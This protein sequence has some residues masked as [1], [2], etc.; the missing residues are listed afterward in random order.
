MTRRAGTPRPTVE[1]VLT[2]H[3][4]KALIDA[5]HLAETAE[6]ERLAA[7]SDGSALSRRSATRVQNWRGLLELL[8][9][10]RRH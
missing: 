1:L 5:L 10:T 4:V 3:E 8:E 6:V 7:M 2:T 9:S